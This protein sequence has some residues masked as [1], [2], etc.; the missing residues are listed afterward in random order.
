MHIKV[1]FVLNFLPAYRVPVFER[2]SRVKDLGITVVY[3][4]IFKE[5]GKLVVN[6]NEAR[7][8]ACRHV[9]YREYRIG[10]I[11]LRHLSGL[12]SALRE[13]R[14]DVIVMTDSRGNFSYWLCY[15]WAMLTGARIYLWVCGHETQRTGSF[16]FHV[17]RVIGK[18]FFGYADRLMVYSTA[19]KRL[20][21]ERFGVAERKITVCYNGIE[22]A[23][24]LANQEAVEHEA[25]AIRASLGLAGRKVFL[26]VG[27]LIPTKRIDQLIR[28]FAALKDP[29]GT[30]LIVGEGPAREALTQQARAAGGDIRFLGRIVKEVESYFAA[31]DYFV[32]PRLGGLALNQAM[33]WRKIC[34][35]STAD[36]TEDD[37]VID[38]VTGIRFEADNEASLLGALGRAMGLPEETRR[39]MG[40]RAR[41]II[42]E[43]NNAE[44]MAATFEQAF[45]GDCKPPRSGHTA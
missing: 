22:I 45:R 5:I 13:L 29:A 44:R 32:L 7:P 33:F 30:L 16:M 14:P 15:L 31:C 40:E 9:K 24:V 39:A 25:Q 8:F 4:P 21:M 37:L 36:G 12:W 23:G 34:I 10:S 26:F 3:S 28:A 42:L 27:G 19:A 1:A 20:M 6:E 18:L 41:K 35:C 38:G 17:K 43:Q 2:L 11:I